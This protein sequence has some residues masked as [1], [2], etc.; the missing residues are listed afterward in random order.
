MR[1]T[2]FTLSQGG[3][4]EA[5]EQSVLDMVASVQKYVPGYRL[6]QKVQFERVGGNVVAAAE[7]ANN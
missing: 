4:K 7:P 1:D 6:K 5:I 3:S 2:V